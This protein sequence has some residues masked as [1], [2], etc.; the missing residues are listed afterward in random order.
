V[1][2]KSELRDFL[3][4]LNWLWH[5]VSFAKVFRVVY[6]GRKP[7]PLM[8]FLEA[9]MLLEDGSSVFYDPNGVD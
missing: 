9:C 8:T 7:T 6:M 5:I 1:S 3:A 4:F 2:F